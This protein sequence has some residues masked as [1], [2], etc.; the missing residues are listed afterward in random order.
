M[1]DVWPYLPMPEISET[2]QWSTEVA[3][4]ETGEYRTSRRAAVQSIT[5]TF[6][7]DAGFQ[8]AIAKL[9]AAPYGPWLVPLWFQGT[10]LAIS[11]TDTSLAVDLDADWTDQAIIWENCDSYQVVDISGITTGIDLT[12]AVGADYA[13]AVVMPLR[14]CR[15]PNGA[16]MS[17]VMKTVSA[18]EIQFDAVELFDQ[19]G[20]SYPQYDSIPYLPCSAPFVSAASGSLYQDVEVFDSGYGVFEVSP[21]RD[22]LENRFEVNIVH[23]A[24]DDRQEFRRFL[25]DVRGREGL[26]WVK[27]WEGGL[28]LSA[29]LLS[30]ATEAQ[31][32]PFADDTASLIGR[33]VRFG[34][35]VREIL[36][37][38][39]FG[40]T[41]ELQFDALT[42]DADT[43]TLLR[44][45]R[46]DSDVLAI[47]H[48]RGLAS[49]AKI[50]VREVSE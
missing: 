10:R 25:G 21:M 22:I 44:K 47:S 49:A 11:S 29:P 50:A 33:F 13:Q 39:E 38:F 27:D 34:S 43:A 2:L 48:R 24:D 8:K 5:Y 9:T 19:T 6:V 7:K 3:E 4:T 16:Q 36:V 40:G 20:A 41:I 28:T 18:V 23:S 17:R 46:L 35:E 1:P 14:T 42:A 26:F 45:V 32:E 31:V 37:A 12:A 30:G 15:T